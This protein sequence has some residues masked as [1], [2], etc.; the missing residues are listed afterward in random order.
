MIPNLTIIGAV[1]VTIRLATLARRAG[2]P[3]A[4]A[5]GVTWTAYMASLTS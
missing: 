3:D 1:Y 2:C 4:R 5:R